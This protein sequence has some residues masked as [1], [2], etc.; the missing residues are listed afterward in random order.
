LPPLRERKEDIEPI[1]NYFLASEDKSFVLSKAA[2]E[3]LLNYDWKGNVREL[4]SI[5]KRA[6]IFAK[7]SGRNIIKLSDLPEEIASKG[8]IN[9]DELILDSLREKKFSHSSINETAKEL[10]LTRNYVSEN[11]RGI[12]FKA[13][14]E[15]GFNVDNAVKSVCNSSDEQA[16]EKV[17]SKALTFLSNV[18]KD[19][20]ALKHL[21]IDEVKQKLNSKYKNLPQKF[22]YYLDEI[23]LRILES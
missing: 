12:I 22:H 17:K 1:A 10:E 23:I 15:A 3:Q 21:S 5:I 4:E 6:I 16:S 8:H 9:F 20:T 11:F 18:E 19:V 13:Y 7:S 14:Y 2:L